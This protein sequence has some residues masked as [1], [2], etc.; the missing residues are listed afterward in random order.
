MHGRILTAM[1][2]ACNLVL[3]CLAQQPSERPRLPAQFQQLTQ[4]KQIQQALQP[5]PVNV[6]NVFERPAVGEPQLLL[7]IRIRTGVPQ[8]VLSAT[9][10]QRGSIDGESGY[11]LPT[12]VVDF[13]D[14]TVLDK[15]S[16][17]DDWCEL[18]DQQKT[19]LSWA[20]KGELNRLAREANEWRER[21]SGA[22]AHDAGIVRAAVVEVA[23][24][25]S[26][27]SD[28]SVRGN[29]LF[30]LVLSNLLSQ[31]QKSRLQR[32]QLL[33]HLQSWRLPLTAAE[34]QRLLE[35][36]LVQE[37]TRVDPPVLWEPQYSAELIQRLD[38][39]KLQEFLTETQLA[40]LQRL[41]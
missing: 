24:L 22:T 21:Y 28:F 39:D 34:Q 40:A 29:S 18:T 15:I 37:K 11:Q 26:Q 36:M 35:L 1:L 32:S 14:R 16:S 23:D 10:S 3:V 33:A 41:R 13:F 9:R 19:K 25:N 17:I 2:C 8:F 12:E 27:L 38:R 20:G 30:C 5:P 31:E 4:A 6:A 7:S